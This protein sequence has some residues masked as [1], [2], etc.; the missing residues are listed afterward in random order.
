MNVV[1]RLNEIPIWRKI[2]QCL[3]GMEICT[4]VRNPV[5]RNTF[6]EANVPLKWEAML[7]RQLSVRLVRRENEAVE[8][9]SS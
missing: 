5:E 4:N 3:N 1:L 2:A 7:Q 6:S 9:R 8:G